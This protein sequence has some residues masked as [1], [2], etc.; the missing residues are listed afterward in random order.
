MKSVLYFF[1]LVT[2]LFA[3]QGEWQIVQTPVNANLK[4]IHAIDSSNIWAAGDSGYI[5]YTSDLGKN[6]SIQRMNENFNIN[7]I[8]FLN[9][10]LGWAVENGNDGINVI[11]NLL[12]TT[13]GGKVWQS[14]R[15]RPD[16]VIIYSICF[17]DSNYGIIGGEG[18]FSF[19]SNGGIDWNEI[20]R[21]SAL[22]SNFPVRK[23]RYVN[24]TI[25]FAVGGYY[26]FGGVIWHSY[27]SG[28]NWI[29]DS[30]YADPFFDF[31][32]LNDSTII[33]IASDIER[34]FPS[35]VFKT[36]NLGASWLFNEIPYYGVSRG[37]SKRT[38]AEIWA[39][40]QR[41]FIYSSDGGHNWFTKSTPDGIEV[42]DI[43][44]LDSIQGFAVAENGKFLKYIPSTLNVENN[45]LIDEN[46][47]TL[48]QNFPNPFNSSTNIQIVL[49][50]N[51]FIKLYITNSIGE[52]L[53]TLFDGNLS[54]GL[55]NFKFQ[56]DFLA[57]GVYFYVL[58]V[59]NPNQFQLNHRAI[60]KMILLK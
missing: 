3:Q 20:N 59:A 40:Y 24:D 37:I 36:T 38:I 47:F 21:D 14:N 17:K 46:G 56:G 58:E 48:L 6:W 13:D 22:F 41:E 32:L 16:N 49:L 28:R 50:I 11:N 26:D 43:T 33:T 55:H 60:G 31:L 30:A 45:N 39:T 34:S 52:K 44:F 15:F 53:L 9:D 10:S 7:D 2:S 51:N 27:D 42:F 1:F 35:A 12:R 19:T 57:S 18:I 5:L 54:K 8:F 23:L 25:A 29:T 4:F